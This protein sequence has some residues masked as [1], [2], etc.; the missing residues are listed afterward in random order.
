MTL[1]AE[2]PPDAE[3]ARR[4]CAECGHTAGRIHITRGKGKLD[5]NIRGYNNAARFAPWLILRDLNGDARCPPELVEE[6]VPQRAPLLEFRIAVR[7]LEAWLLADVENLS[8]YLGVSVKL[9]PDEPELVPNPKGTLVN[10]ARRSRRRDIRVDMTPATGTSAAVGRGY[11]GRLIEFISSV[12]QPANAALRSDSL[13]RCIAA[14][15]RFP[16]L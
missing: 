15:R 7:T 5:S 13:R 3:L 1:V 11:N 8:K 12:W 4:L 6:L 10:L 9:F 2:G 14:V 16:P